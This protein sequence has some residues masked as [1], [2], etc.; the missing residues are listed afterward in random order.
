MKKSILILSLL[1]MLVAATALAASA[2]AFID[3][4]TDGD[5]QTWRY[6]VTADGAHD[7]SHFV[8]GI[9]Q[10]YEVVECDPTDCE[11]GL[12]PSTQVYGVKWDLEIPVGE[13]VE[14]SF[15]TRSDDPRQGE[16]EWSVKE[17]QNI[18]KGLTTGPVCPPNS[19]KLLGMSVTPD[20][21]SLLIS[22]TVALIVAALIVL[23]AEI[24][25][26]RRR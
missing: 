8:V 23:M 26:R 14:V 6:R 9:G 15:T 25:R 5:L 20:V 13:S 12:D 16:V 17:G 4:T 24:Q 21:P 19:V 1:V 11:L 7:I 10:C 2:V 18:L 22:L 3:V